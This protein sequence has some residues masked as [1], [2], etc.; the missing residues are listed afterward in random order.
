MSALPEWKS[1][2]C[3]EVLG[4]LGE[5][6]PTVR[7]EERMLKG[8][9]DGKCY[10]DPGD[11]RRMAAAFTEAADWLDKRAEADAIP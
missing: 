7:V 8:Y 9:I 1:L 3:A 10:Y 4:D 6:S 11:L 2:A 5:F